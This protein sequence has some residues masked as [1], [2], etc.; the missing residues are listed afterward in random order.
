MADSRRKA[1]GYILTVN[2]LGE[3]SLETDKSRFV[4]I[5]FLFPYS[6][7]WLSLL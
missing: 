1:I 7:S 4:F 5:C 6:Y 2:Y 3:S